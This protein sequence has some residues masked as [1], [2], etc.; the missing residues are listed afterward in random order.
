MPERELD[1]L[2]GNG[3]RDWFFDTP[4]DHMN[5]RNTKRNSTEFVTEY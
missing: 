2:F 3:G 5:D 4:S 1:E